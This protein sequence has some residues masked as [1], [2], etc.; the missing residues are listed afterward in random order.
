MR[1]LNIN[2][3]TVVVCMA[4]T[5]LAAC[6]GGSSSVPVVTPPSPVLQPGW[7]LTGSLQT[8]RNGHTATLL[9]DGRVLAVGGEYDTIGTPQYVYPANAE[10]YDP[11]TNFW[12]PAGN[13][14]QARSGHTATLLPN[15]KVLVV[16]GIYRV[17]DQIGVVATAELYDPATNTWTVASSPVTA[18]S[19]HTATLLPNGKVLVSG[20]NDSSFTSLNGVELYDPA[21]NA[22]TSVGTLL[23]ARQGHLATLLPNGKV[24]V[25]G[26]LIAEANQQSFAATAELY[27]P[28][29]QTSTAAATPAIR[30]YGGSATLL[31]SG[32]V[33]F[34]ADDLI[35]GDYAVSALYNPNTNTWAPAGKLSTWH[36]WHAATRL[37]NGK[38]LVVG[39]TH[40]G[41]RPVYSPTDIAELYDPQTNTW[42]MTQALVHGPR[43]R[44]TAT[45]LSNG[46]VLVAGGSEGVSAP[47]TSAGAAL[48][49]PSP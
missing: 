4:V 33:L 8:A 7:T 24:L 22:W 48:Y 18:R 35:A 37:P 21:T 9:A 23:T 32:N 20:G 19:S 49:T 39:G 28:A 16:G 29:T 1:F 31:S 47:Y 30:A 10:L 2:L 34:V 12:T 44:H 43:M 17:G 42:S 25:N 26:G 36:Y 3:G 41:V 27:D 40:V 15:G 6:G 11:A 5:V 13:L 38:V 14:A 45:L 46:A